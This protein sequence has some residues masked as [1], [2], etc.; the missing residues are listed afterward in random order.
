MIQCCLTPFSKLNLLTFILLNID[1]FMK[2]VYTQNNLH[3]DYEYMVAIYGTVN[4]V[5]TAYKF[6]QQENI[7]IYREYEG[8]IEKSV[9]RITVWR[10]EACRVMTNSDHK[11]YFSIQSSHK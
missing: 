11:T 9:P 3:I 5:D 1:T 10:N 2:T 6:T 7:R 4:L 8:G